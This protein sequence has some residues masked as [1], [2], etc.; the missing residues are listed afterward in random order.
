MSA[1]SNFSLYAY[2]TDITPGL[3]LFYGDG[4]AY[5]G[6]H[7]P[8][9]VLQSVNISL[10]ETDESTEFVAT[11]DR[12]MDWASQPTMYI[13]T[14]SDAF[15]PVGFTIGNET[16]DNSSTVTRFGLYGGWAFHRDDE[17]IVE[18]KFYATPINETDIYL[19]RWNAGS[20]KTVDRISISLRTVALI[21]ITS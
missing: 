2:S 15:N 4:Q 13:D 6:T 11:P 5:V 17:G 18:M 10:S 19:V 9:F 12:A 14:T 16:V 21:I 8:S 20:S 7:P 3:K 1:T